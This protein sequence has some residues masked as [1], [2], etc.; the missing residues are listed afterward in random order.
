MLN[1]E[2]DKPFHQNPQ[3]ATIQEELKRF[4]IT[5]QDIQSL[6]QRGKALGEC[7]FELKALSGAPAFAQVIQS[8]NLD[9]RFVRTLSAADLLQYVTH[10]AR[11][12]G[13]Y[14]VE[15]FVPAAGA[16]T[17]QLQILKTILN[18]PSLQE[19]NGVGDTVQAAQLEI[20]RLKSISA[21]SASDKADQKLLE[22]VVIGL[23]N[24]WSV[25]LEQRG[26]AFTGDLDAYFNGRGS[27]LAKQVDAENVR[28]VARAILEEDGLGYQQL[29]KLLMKVHVY[30]SE[31]GLESRT[32]LEEHLREAALVQ[33]SAPRLR[34]HFAISE[35]H[36]ELAEQTLEKL[37]QKDAFVYALK[38]AGFSRETVDVT[39][40]FQDAT[41][42]A[43]ALQL[44]DGSVARDG[45]GEIVLRK[46]GHG[47]LLK[48]LSASSCDGV[49]L[50]NVDNVLYDNPTVKPMVVAYKHALAGL[51]FSLQ[52][53]SHIL[54]R[55]LSE[56]DSA[57]SSLQMGIIQSAQKFITE[58][59]QCTLPWQALP[60]ATEISERARM[61]MRLL[62]RPIIVGGYV[63]L[64]PGQSGGG[65][66]VVELEMEPGVTVRKVNTVEG[67]EFDGGGNSPIFKSG[68]FFN[69]VLFFIA[70]RSPNGAVYPLESMRDES[71]F[72]RSQKSNA[73]GSMMATFELPGLWN[74]SLALAHQV[75][76]AVPGCVFSP[77]KDLASS[78]ASFLAPL[79]RPMT[80]EPFKAIDL[81]SG[82]LTG[83][84]QSYLRGLIKP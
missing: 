39:F 80:G 62:D 23:P 9:N 63:P 48:N 41:T 60:E 31:F 8:A 36:L 32:M 26:Y 72:F 14:S 75:S 81:Q 67:A 29:P 53:E 59:L 47:A 73:D 11:I 27:S 40:S 2:S 20:Q 74:G 55:A 66:F 76:V 78:D 43:V 52:E 4:Q 19:C 28:E 25:G 65:P 51:A 58:S 70:R 16:A 24:M 71:R 45:G 17:R 77:I 38:G 82:A 18:H 35:E 6:N 69:P 30:P 84:T 42:D 49:W 56:I 13:D 5:E 33:C 12:S 57:G 15:S 3:S 37:W 34:L 46:A 79:H 50:Q 54:F 7:L 44:K 61:L 64:E 1:P 10:G 22:E 83:A 21:P 68:A